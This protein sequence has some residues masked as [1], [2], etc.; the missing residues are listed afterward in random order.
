MGFGGF[1]F[2][3]NLHEQDSSV[4]P[5]SLSIAVAGSTHGGGEG[6]ER[7]GEQPPTPE[8]ILKNK[9]KSFVLKF[10]TPNRR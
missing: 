5:I 10:R 1:Q 6:R 8:L 4:L 9:C 3:G 2:L 7:G